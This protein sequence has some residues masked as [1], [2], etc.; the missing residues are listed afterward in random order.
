MLYTGAKS[1]CDSSLTKEAEDWVNGLDGMLKTLLNE[2]GN[3]SWNYTTNLTDENAA[4]VCRKTIDDFAGVIPIGPTPNDSMASSA[5]GLIAS[6]KCVIDGN[7]FFT[8]IRRQHLRL[9]VQYVTVALDIVNKNKNKIYKKKSLLTY[10]K[11]IL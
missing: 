8:F 4:K 10:R 5:G 2:L 11:I 9:V 6:F 3:A 7:S 1:A